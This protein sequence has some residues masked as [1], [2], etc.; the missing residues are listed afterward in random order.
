[1]CEGE[2]IGKPGLLRGVLADQRCMWME[3]EAEESLKEV[4]HVK[5]SDHRS[6]AQ[7]MEAQQSGSPESGSPSPVSSTSTDT[8]KL[9]SVQQILPSLLNL[10]NWSLTSA[11]GNAAQNANQAHSNVLPRTSAAANFLLANQALGLQQA[12]QFLQASANTSQP[13]LSMPGSGMANNNQLL[14]SA[15]AGLQAGNNPQNTPAGVSL[16]NQLQIHQLLNSGLSGN[17]VLAAALNNQLFAAAQNQL[18]QS[19]MMNQS[20]VIRRAGKS[21]VGSTGDVGQKSIVMPHIMK[22]EDT[23]EEDDESANSENGLDDKEERDRLDRGPTIA[24]LTNTP[25]VIRSTKSSGYAHSNKSSFNLNPKK[26][27]SPPTSASS[28]SS[29]P[30]S[31]SPAANSA[32]HHRLEKS[33]ICT[34]RSATSNIVDGI[35]LE[36]IRE[37]AK[38]FK[39]RRLS[40]G[41]T[42]TQ[43]GQALSATEG[44]SYSQSAICRFEKLDITPRSAQKI[45]PVLER[46]MKEAEERYENGGQNLAE[47]VGCEPNK[48]RKRRTSF[49]PQA[50][51]VLNAHFEKNTHPS[52]AEVTSLADELNYDR[53]VVR[54]WFCNKRQA[55]KNTIKK[56]KNSTN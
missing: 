26:S 18:A 32:R 56:I 55:L 51:E 35:D 12:Q 33:V 28:P 15:L 1:M 27:V 46:W 38:R 29:A 25:G 11:L 5:Y 50:L 8:G 22:T 10:H 34:A 2:N 52:G 53:E 54:V 23:D 3:K 4:K 40:L 43:V 39:M 9:P 48:K 36:E 41:L 17:Q 13:M 49:T 16:M 47:F 42:Q 6:H 19:G 44:P 7:T 14:T 20:S 45:K 24:Q 31:T 21:S 30:T 37:F